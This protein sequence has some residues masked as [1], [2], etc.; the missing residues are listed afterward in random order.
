LEGISNST[1]LS[2][3]ARNRLTGEAKF[4]RA[5]YYFYLVNL[6]DSVPLITTTDYASN[7]IQARSS[8]TKIDELIS[9]DLQDAEQALSDAA[10][11]A[12]SV[13][14][15]LSAVHFLQAR[16]FLFQKDWTNALKAANE[17]LGSSAYS[18]CS[19]LDQVFLKGSPETVWQLMPVAPGANTWDGFYYILLFSPSNVA[20]SPS[21][22]SAFEPGDMRRNK[23]IDSVSDNGIDYF[24]PDKY[25]LKKG[26]D[27]LEYQVVFR[28]S[29]M[30]LVRAEAQAALGD[31]PKA[32]ADL[33]LIRSR[34]GLP[35]VSATDLQTFL[36]YLMH[37]RQV[38]L[39]TEWGARW[40]DLKRTGL[41]N[42]VLSDVKGA[43]WQATD[44]LFPIPQSEIQNDPNLVQ[45]E[46]Y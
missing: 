1:Y 11:Q 44:M 3:K 16:Y 42:S 12:G 5:F 30:I 43:D 39:F 18:L 29:E 21:L 26:I 46:G 25:K 38:E 22:L 17:V 19:D 2:G 28:L 20:L 36:N 4:L 45:N 40:F 31:L 34:A 24:F 6:F 9:Q 13:R 10:D 8:R 7:V 23:W 33:N 27:V 35:P 15:G 32:D 41:A 37:E 14:P